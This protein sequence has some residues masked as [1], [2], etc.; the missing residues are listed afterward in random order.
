[1]AS[2]KRARYAEGTSV[3]A[4]RSLL[5]IRGYMKRWGGEGFMHMEDPDTGDV[6]IG[7]RLNGALYRFPLPMPRRKDYRYDSTFEAE[8]RRRWRVLAAFTKAQLFG[9]EEGLIAPEKALLPFRVLPGG[10]TLA[11]LMDEG[12]LDRMLALP[13]GE[14]TA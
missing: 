10:S 13:P 2:G 7:F 5:E 14:K 9:I 12:H 4:D 8:V 3:S 6:R 11:E 1:M